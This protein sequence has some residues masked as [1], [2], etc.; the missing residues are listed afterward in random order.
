LFA[1]YACLGRLCSMPALLPVLVAILPA[2]AVPAAAAAQVP[3]F[4]YELIETPPQPDAIDL[5]AGNVAVDRKE[6]WFLQNGDVSVRNV[7]QPTLTPELP[8]GPSSGAAVVVAPGGG[9]LGP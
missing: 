4:H 7:V 6:Q 5:P 1:T 3:T 2:L 9:F 8:A